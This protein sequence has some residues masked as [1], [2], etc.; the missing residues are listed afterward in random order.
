MTDFSINS[1]V[2]IPDG[3]RPVNTSSSSLAGAAV[4]QSLRLW[5]PHASNVFEDPEVR[6]QHENTTGVDADDHGVASLVEIEPEAVGRFEFELNT[7]GDNYPGTWGSP[8]SA[9]RVR[10]ESSTSL[11]TFAR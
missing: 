1:A 6:I 2:W 5:K 4:T 8:S 11:R 9:M 7:R 3:L 10:H